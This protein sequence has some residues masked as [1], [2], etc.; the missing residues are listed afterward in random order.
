M[1]ISLQLGCVEDVCLTD[2][3][4]ALSVTWSNSNNS[5]NNNINNNNN[6]WLDVY[7]VPT[8]MWLQELQIK[9]PEI[10]QDEGSEEVPGEESSECESSTMRV[11]HF[12]NI[13]HSSIA[14]SVIN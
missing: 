10:V 13:A 14:G 8:E 3:G 11:H 12:S 4:S 9:P 6:K 7:K 1:F 5:N 2:D